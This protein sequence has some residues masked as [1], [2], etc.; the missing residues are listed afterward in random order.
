MRATRIMVGAIGL[1]VIGYAI[2][3]LFTDDGVRIAGVLPLLVG[4]VIAHDLILMPIAIG[5]GALATRY[6]PAWCRRLVQ[7]GLWVSAAVT[8]FAL[9]FIIGAGRVPDNPSKLPRP[10]GAGLAITLGVIWLVVAGLAARTR[11]HH[12]PGT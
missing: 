5:L 11:R 2:V 9:P 1:A 8:A 6:V 7:G 3:G 10:Y 4:L 12:R